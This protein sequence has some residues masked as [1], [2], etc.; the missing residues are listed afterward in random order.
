MP[1]KKAHPATSPMDEEK[2]KNVFKD[3]LPHE[4][5]EIKPEGGWVLPNRVKFPTWIHENFVY[6]QNTE[7]LLFP[8][9]RF[10]KDFIQYESPYRGILLYHSVGLGKSKAS[11]VAAENLIG[12]MKVVV[13]LPAS[14][15]PNY[16]EEIK[17]GTNT[18]FSKQQHWRKI[19]LE[20][21]KDILEKVSKE[22]YVPSTFIKKQGGV[23][24]PTKH[25]NVNYDAL[26]DHEKIEVNRQL[27]I[28]ISNKYEFIHYNGLKEEKIKAMTKNGNPFDNKV[29]IIDE[30][31]NVISATI[32]KARIMKSIYELLL[33]AKNAKLILLSGTPIINYPFEISFLVNLLRGP[34]QLHELWWKNTFDADNVNAEF[35]NNPYVDYFHVD[36]TRKNVKFQLLPHGFVYQN[37]DECLV[38]RDDSLVSEAAIIDGI[39]K[40]INASKSFSETTYVFP[41]VSKVRKT[42]G[43][44]IKGE[45]SVNEFKEEFNKHYIDFA[46]EQVKN[47]RML[48]RRMAGCISYFGTYFGEV[49]PEQ[50]PVRTV[51][52][53]M[54]DY[55][56]G[57][58]EMARGKERPKEEASKRFGKKDP[59]APDDIFDSTGQ[60]YRAYSRAVCNFAFPVDKDEP[61]LKRPYPAKISDMLNEM[62]LDNDEKKAQEKLKK[63]EESDVKNTD[64]K[65]TYKEEI[66]VALNALESNSAE[67]LSKSSLK[68]NFS[69]KYAKIIEILENKK[70]KSL[71]YSQFRT[72][73]GLGVLSLSLNANGWAEFKLSKSASGWE[74]DISEE[75][76]NKPKY[77]QYDGNKEETK[78]LMKIFNNELNDVPD[79]IMNKLPK[80]INNLRGDIIKLI[81]ITQS[82]AEGISLKHVRHI[83]ILEPYWNELRNKQIIGRAVRA[84][85]H[86]DLPK[87]EQNVQVFRYLMKFN[88]HQAND[89]AIKKDK[90]M[91]TDQYLFNIAKRKD[92]IIGK[93]QSLMQT[94]AV[95][96]LVH[97]KLQHS[98][99]KC[100]QYP[101]NLNPNSLSYQLD[102]SKEELDKDYEDKVKKIVTGTVCKKCR[103][104]TQDYAYD[105]KTHVLYDLQAYKEKKLITIGKLVK[106]ETTGHYK[107]VM[108]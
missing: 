73:E 74:L 78:L 29:V 1:P 38:K 18:F 22:T 82:G 32:S 98:A 33:F 64:V 54:T 43:R 106:N 6:Q 30:V 94:T 23:W 66:K 35:E 88:D 69:P 70:L 12:K 16:I 56:F 79:S 89:G 25:S 80:N 99:I 87:A 60:V 102:Y 58:Y 21:F 81:M 103:I 97:S 2:F 7:Q 49:Y 4:N 104:G 13:M 107:V 101:K 72:V 15:E 44:L 41:M 47:P 11:I 37:K 50:L 27:D 100:L 83:H 46:S 93:I 26:A 3:Y 86:T 40:K 76:M 92:N 59:A 95:D 28:M 51:Y 96:C 42:E 67:Y 63:Q 61:N 48:A 62:A 65:N 17:K 5:I 31:H 19:P 77:F 57:V 71:A 68:E 10:I 52:L 75:D 53:Y 36:T 14:L 39:A 84:Y 91:T 90:M 85:S 8:S 55:Q 45:S 34:Q 105:P 24:I 20:K 108:D 9:Q